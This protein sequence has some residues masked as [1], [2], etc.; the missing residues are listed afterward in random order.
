MKKN[1]VRYMAALGVLIVL[2]TGTLYIMLQSRQ[3]VYGSI[4]DWLSQHVAFADY[5]RE[6]FYQTGQLFPDFSLQLG[7]GQN[8]A[9]FI[10]YG[11]LRPEILLSYAFPMIKM[12]T[13]ITVSSIAL[14]ITSTELFYYWI[15][16]QNISRQAAFFSSIIFLC[17]G[18]MLFHTHKHVMFINYMPWL[19]LTFIGIQRYLQKKKSALMITGI[20]LMIL[21][22]YFYSVS[23]L[24]MCGIYAIYEILRMQKKIDYLESLKTIGRL[25]GHVLIGVG[26]SC[27]ILL[28]TVIM[29]FSHTRE[30]IQAPTFMELMKPDMDM[31]ALTYTGFRSNAY[32]A[33]MC[34]IAWAAVVYFIFRNAK[35]KR[36]LGIMTLLITVIPLFCYLLNGLQYVREK[37]LIPMIPLVGYMVAEMLSEMENKPSRRLLWIVPFL[38]I[39]YFFIELEKLKPLYLIDA[40]FCSGILIVY[41][42]TRRKYIF[43]IYLL[44]PLLLTMPTN[45]VENFVKQSQLSKFENADKKTQV[46]AVLDQDSSLYRFDDLHYALRTCNQVLDSRMYKTS[47]YSSNRNQEYSYFADKVMGMPGP[48]TNNATITAEKN[49]FFQSMMSVKYLY[50]KG[51]VPLHYNILSGDKNGYV[52]VNE[53]VLPMGYATSDLLSQ[54]QFKKLKYPYSMEAIYNNAIVENAEEKEWESKLQEVQLSYKLIHMDDTVSVKKVKNGYQLTVRKKSTINLRLDQSIDGQLLILD[55]P[56]TEIQKPSKTV[57]GIEINGIVNKRGSNSDMYGNKR[58]NF[59]YILDENKPWKDLI[60]KLEKGSYIIQNPKAYLMDGSVLTKRN[61]NIDALKGERMSGNNVLKGDIEVRDDGYFVTS[62]PFD[63]GF[64]VRLDKKEIAYEKVNT[65]FV[66]F[67]IK[68]G[69]HTIEITYQMPGKRAGV[70]ISI[71]SLLIGATLYLKRKVSVQRLKYRK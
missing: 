71:L 46:K 33:G 35:E 8:M 34:V 16:K 51:A 1:D 32:S 65:A 6:N 62:I 39:P 59:R 57:V 12:S 18:P 15:R 64:K 70:M 24:F 68:K 44:F 17:A 58:N 10:Y 63:K 30:A 47:L 45:K 50:G 42:F 56:I 4:T 13:Y 43:G 61:K 11:L 27:F 3:L 9:E 48:S 20:V 66:G 31:S 2:I 7:A 5:F 69:H 67:P 29:M 55:L 60:L 21:E 28:P 25:M 37:S 54:Q 52:A 14:T 22:S 36:A 41:T 23:A 49:S 53:N 40:L 19:I 26:I 38:F